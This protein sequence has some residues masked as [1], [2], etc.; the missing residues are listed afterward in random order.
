VFKPSYGIDSLCEQKESLANPGASGL[1]EKMSR[2]GTKFVFFYGCSVP[3]ILQ[4]VEKTPEQILE[5]QVSIFQEWLEMRKRMVLFCRAKYI[6]VKLRKQKLEAAQKSE[7]A[8]TKTSASD[9][10][11]PPRSLPL[12]LNS[13]S[14]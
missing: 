7:A 2:K 3:V 12:H 8:E 5:D 6:K 4:E 10:A 11:N 13:E 14:L 1:F 9:F